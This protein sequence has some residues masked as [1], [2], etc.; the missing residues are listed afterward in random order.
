MASSQT[1]RLH[2][3][4]TASAPS[5]DFKT[6]WKACSSSA[7]DWDKASW[8]C[9]TD[10]RAL[11]VR[12]SSF[13]LQFS[14]AYHIMRGWCSTWERGGARACGCETPCSCV[15]N[16][17]RVC[18]RV[19]VLW[20]GESPA[21]ADR[22]EFGPVVPVP[23]ALSSPAPSSDGRCDHLGISGSC[24]WTEWI[25]PSVPRLLPDETL[26]PA[27]PAQE[28]K[29]QKKK[30][31]NKTGTQIVTR[32]GLRITNAVPQWEPWEYYLIH[33]FGVLFFLF[34]VWGLTECT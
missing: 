33:K 5:S 29:K 8:A 19:P 10:S 32:T 18:M 27:E 17:I 24:G 14:A 30:N 25:F 3:P 4:P 20:A 28:R 21:A 6:S 11:R 1:E 7:A 22:W 34:R 9:F 26:S 31:K 23:L 13:R 2:S 16:L 15:P 12:T